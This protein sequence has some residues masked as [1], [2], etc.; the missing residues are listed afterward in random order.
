MFITLFGDDLPPL[1]IDLWDSADSTLFLKTFKWEEVKALRCQS[2]QSK[3]LEAVTAD[4]VVMS[5]LDT[6]WLLGFSWT[7]TRWRLAFWSAHCRNDGLVIWGTRPHLVIM[8][9][10]LLTAPVFWLMTLLLRDSSWKLN[11][12][13]FCSSQHPGMASYVDL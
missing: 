10:L 3:F 12:C 13:R 1:F 11:T 2:S 7:T 4:L 9:L 8:D 6:R 5:N